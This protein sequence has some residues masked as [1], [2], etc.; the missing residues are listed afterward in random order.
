M[1]VHKTGSLGKQKRDFIK[2]L[3][4]FFY[5]P[6]VQGELK[7]FIIVYKK[8]WICYNFQTRMIDKAI[9]IAWIGRVSIYALPRKV[10]MS[11]TMMILVTAKMLTRQEK[12]SKQEREIHNQTFSASISENI[13]ISTSIHFFYENHS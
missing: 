12:E 4:S 3:L 13:L 7:V 9:L 2:M 1:L 10:I 6:G 5:C 11:N 8:S